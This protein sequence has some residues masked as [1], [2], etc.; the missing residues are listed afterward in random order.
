MFEL[1]HPDDVSELRS[2]IKELEDG[3]EVIRVIGRIRRADGRWRYLESTVG[4]S[5]AGDGVTT[6]LTRDVEDRIRLEAEL[7]RQADTDALTGL[8][9]R[10]AFL[11]EL[12]RR[13]AAGPATVLFCDLDGF[14][15]VNGT[16][17]HAVGDALLRQVADTIADAVR[18][19]DLVAR[20]GGDEF[21]VLLPAGTPDPPDVAERLC[22]R[23]VDRLS[24]LRT[25][26]VLG[27]SIGLVT[28]GEAGECVDAAELLGDADLA[29]YEAKAAGG[30]HWVR[31]EPSMRERVMARSQLRADL[32][33]VIATGGLA[34]DLQPLVDLVTGAWGGF[35]ALIRWPDPDRR[36]SP[37]DF[38]PLAE[39]TGLI[40]PLGAW[41]LRT[42]LQ[43]LAAWPD[44]QAGVSVNVTGRQVADPGFADLV[45]GELDRAGVDPGRLT[46][47]ITEQTAV[48]DLTRASAV[49]QPLRALGVHV[50]LDDFGTGFSSLG[51]LA[52]LPVDE[53]KIDQSFVGGLG[54]RAHDDALVRAVLGMAADLGLRVVAEGCRDGRTG[55]DPARVRLPGRAGL[56]LLPTRAVRLTPAAGVGAA[57]GRSGRRVPPLSWPD[58]GRDDVRPPSAGDGSSARRRLCC[59]NG[60]RVRATLA[61]WHWSWAW[62]SSPCAPCLPA[63]HGCSRPPR[64]C[65]WPAAT[66]S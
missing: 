29:M 56:L 10:K 21:A 39:E 64:I 20:L 58:P 37:G 28:G 42:A 54:S 41:V 14:K 65:W 17:G 8:L 43:W 51:Y 4:R 55:P 47:E 61:L 2:R 59:D 30:R 53:L 12:R 23:L 50:A 32:E 60:R 34:I 18:E 9:N 48:E 27:V 49:L 24:G 7:R 25:D 52:Q 1:V 46:L 66:P 45:R 16:E 13:L 11:S 5:T 35:E 31:F 33:R 15:A 36:R 38:L 44:R 3:A 63:P 40:V 6:V 57:P 62:G 19:G 22:E 26:G